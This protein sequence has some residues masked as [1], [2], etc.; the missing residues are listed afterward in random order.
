MKDKWYVDELYYILFIH[1]FEELT[2]FLADRLDARF[3][4]D[5]FHD[6]LVSGGVKF[7]S[8]VRQWQVGYVRRYA[9]A[10]FLGVVVVL[11]V[12]VLSR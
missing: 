6:T 12:F 8:R 10:V 11:G 2:A 5:W 4:H 9:L 1:F 3:W 7:L